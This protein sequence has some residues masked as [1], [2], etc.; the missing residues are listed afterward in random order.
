[1]IGRGL[2]K[3]VLAIGI[4]FTAMLGPVSTAHAWGSD[5]HRTVGA[6][7]WYELSPAARA[8]VE[9][10]VGAGPE[11]LADAAAWPDEV[12]RA[13]PEY[14]WADRLHYVNVPFDAKRY[15]G[16]RDC[17]QKCVVSAIRHYAFVLHDRRASVDA[18]REAL[19]FL[20]HFVG[21]IHQPLHVAHPDG[22][23]GTLTDVSFE[24]R[25]MHVH[26]VWD[27]AIVDTQGIAGV[28]EGAPRWPWL[29]YALR[30]EIGPSERAAWR[31]FDPGT[32][33]TESLRLSQSVPQPA[34]GAVLDRAWALERWPIVR[35]RVQQAGVRLAALLERALAE[36]ASWPPEGLTWESSSGA[37]TPR[38]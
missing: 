19:R 17:P 21:D 36:D 22:R 37:L 14:G 32:W 28:P 13:D 33:A 20:A 10:L 1:M 15:R 9:A 6:I 3:S 8:E 29:T 4:A 27:E 25:N 38:G 30:R 34:A 18:R 2:V 23:G 11:G 24:G 5:G 7:A 35:V 12:A 31:S 16:G 26:A